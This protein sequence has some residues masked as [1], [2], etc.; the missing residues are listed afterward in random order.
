VVPPVGLAV[1]HGLA[2]LLVPL[3]LMAQPAS[4]LSRVPA[5]ARVL[6]VLVCV[7]VALRR[8][9]PVLAMTV[10]AALTALMGMI[11]A[12]PWFTD[13]A[14]MVLVIYSAVAHGPRWLVSAALGLAV[15]GPIRMLWLA[16]LDGSVGGTAMYIVYTVQVFFAWMLGL[17]ARYR[18]AYLASGEDRADRLEQQRQVEAL[19]AVAAGTWRRPGRTPRSHNFST[20]PRRP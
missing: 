17:V 6:F 12:G 10:L 8:R 13:L 14:A 20:S 2:G 15:L 16:P 18:L 19:V 11:L 7:S 5:L 1:R 4:D 9:A 3:G